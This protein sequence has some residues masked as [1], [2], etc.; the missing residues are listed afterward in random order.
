MNS[1]SPPDH[2]VETRSRGEKVQPA[3]DR[4]ASFNVHF[5][6]NVFNVFLHGARADAQ[7]AGYFRIRLAVTDPSGDLQFAF[8]QAKII[9]WGGDYIL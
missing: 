7:N 4:H 9:G 8:A 5:F 1:A 3:G 2:S 6:K